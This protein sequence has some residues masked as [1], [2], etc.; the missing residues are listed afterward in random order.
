M[1]LVPAHLIAD[2]AKANEWDPPCGIHVWSQPEEGTSYCIT[3]G[4]T[5]YGAN[6]GGDA[7]K[8][9]ATDMCPACGNQ[10]PFNDDLCGVCTAVAQDV[11][12]SDDQH[13]HRWLNYQCDC[14]DTT[15][16]E[17]NP[18]G[19]ESE[20]CLCG[21]QFDHPVHSTQPDAPHTNY[22]KVKLPVHMFKEC[23]TSLKIYLN[24]CKQCGLGPSSL[25]HSWWLHSDFCQECDST[26]CTADC[27]C[28]ACSNE[29]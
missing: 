17:F 29:T 25:V 14:G 4:R 16:H 28:A 24:L 13:T 3:C 21:T 26:T 11:A 2:T 1:E 10:K 6:Y 20:E 18:M 15:P 7:F 8:S 19:M 27:Q 9:P 22:A 23:A 12:K 5:K